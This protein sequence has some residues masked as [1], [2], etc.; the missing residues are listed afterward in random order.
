MSCNLAMYCDVVSHHCGLEI[1]GTD[2]TSFH[3]DLAINLISIVMF[4][5]DCAASVY[6]DPSLI[7]C[8][9]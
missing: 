7:V 4:V 2:L 5:F 8:Q 6:T 1:C 3:N 9:T